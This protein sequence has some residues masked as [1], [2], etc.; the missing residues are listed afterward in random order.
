MIQGL[1][2]IGNI[3]LLEVL[4]SVDNSAVLATMVMDLPPNQRKKALRYG[5]LG[6]Y[7][8]RGICLLIAAWLAKIWW[9]KVVGGFYLL[10]L[11]FGYFT[12]KD[13]SD[14][15]VDKNK[16]WIYKK[17]IGLV[18]TLWATVIIV[19]VMDLAFSID[20]VFAAV[21]FTS[22][23]GLIYIGVFIGIL[24]MRFVAGLFV[25]L[26]EKFIFLEKVAFIV[27]GVL[28]L[29]LLSSLFTHFDPHGA[30]SG[31]LEGKH[32]D[33]Y[34]SLFTVLAFG[35]PILTSWAFNY[36]KNLGKAEIAEEAESVL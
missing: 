4:L 18:G 5:I 8:F 24:A 1:M 32:F 31:I 23:L 14:D 10:Y 35:V 22:H 20:N 17:V 11:T 36:P 27:I 15:S 25:K 9:L 16:N 7:V 33:L 6:A 19:E 12:K 3:I 13:D 30:I 34:I 26:M 2:I 21:A 29:K 28:G